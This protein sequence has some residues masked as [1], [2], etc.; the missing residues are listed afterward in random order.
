M[1]LD[2]SEQTI[3]HIEAAALAQGVSPQTLIEQA[4]EVFLAQQ[5]RRNTK[6]FVI[7]SFVGSVKSEDPSW[8]DQHEELLWDANGNHR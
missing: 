3:R 1:T 2:L 7:P 4:L 8:I 5:S 6:G